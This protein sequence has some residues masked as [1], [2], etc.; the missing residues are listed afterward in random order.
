LYVHGT[1]IKCILTPICTHFG[2]FSLENLRERER[3]RERET[4]RER[5]RERRWILKFTFKKGN[6]IL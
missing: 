5:K 6:L 2:H 1:T 3:E 4:E